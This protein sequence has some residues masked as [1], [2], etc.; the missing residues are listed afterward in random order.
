MEIF[1]TLG[2]IALGFIPTLAAMELAWRTCTKKFKRYSLRRRPE[3]ILAEA[4]NR[5]QGRFL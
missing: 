4:R 2:W 3:M 5:K 1:E